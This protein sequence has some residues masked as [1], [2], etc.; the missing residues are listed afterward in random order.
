MKIT[1][2]RGH[3]LEA[4]L[5]QAFAYS[6]A[7]YDSRT[8]MLVEIETDT[9]LTGWGE[10]YGPARMTAAVVNNVASWLIGKDPLRTDVLWQTIYARL[11]DHGQKG[12]VI[13]GLSGI[14]SRCGTS[15]ASILACPRISCSAARRVT[16]CRPMPPDF[17]GANRAI[18]SN[19]CRMKR[20]PMPGKAFAP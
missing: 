17:T 16:R 6:R 9:G 12:V 15:R 13:Q 10:C 2:I 19:T 20:P 1:G 14:D 3:F 5:S 18:R 7:W 11:R 8:A 4:K